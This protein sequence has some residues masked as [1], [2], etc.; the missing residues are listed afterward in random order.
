MNKRKLMSLALGLCMVAILAV[1][2]TLAYFTDTDTETNTFTIGNVKIDLVEEFDEEN[3]VLKP[4]SQDKNKIDK[5]V[6]IENVGAEPA[7]LWYEWLIPTALDSIDGSTG[8]NNVLHVNSY[9]ATWD[10]YYTDSK[11]FESYGITAALEFDQTWDHDPEVELGIAVGPQGYFEQV[12][13]DGIQYNKYVVLYHGVVD[14]GEATT[15]AMN[16]VYLDSKVDFNGTD[17]TIDGAVIDYDFDKDIKIIVNAYGI[18]AEG[19]ADVYEAY[20][21]YQLQAQ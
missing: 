3:A 13:I 16:G 11:Y 12:T 18:Q 6:H 17:Y 19:F 4:G 2:G 21:A 9:G 5:I 15:K 20:K 14:A 10:K 8:L 7:Y 1:G